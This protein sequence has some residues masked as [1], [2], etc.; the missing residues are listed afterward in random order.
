ML[1]TGDI[2]EIAEKQILKEYSGKDTL[3]SNILKVGHHGSKTSSTEEFLKA[4]SPNIALIRCSE[5]IIHLD[6]PIITF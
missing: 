6:T 3:K 1:F 4:V 2:E 5:K